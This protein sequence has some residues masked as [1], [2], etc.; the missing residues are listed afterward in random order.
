VGVENDIVQNSFAASDSDIVGVIGVVTGV[1]WIERDLREYDQ[2][3][4]LSALFKGNPGASVE[5]NELI[6]RDQVTV[7]RGVGYGC[8]VIDVVDV[9]MNYSSGYEL[10]LIVL[11]N[12]CS[13]QCPH[14]SSRP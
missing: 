11:Y 5:M 8:A 10:G 6:S 9:E 2:R 14:T 13:I 7:E 1:L 3:R 12:T 4:V